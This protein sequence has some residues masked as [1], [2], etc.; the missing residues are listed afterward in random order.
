MYSR[1]S[2]NSRSKRSREPTSGERRAATTS[3]AMR[4]TRERAEGT[5][6]GPGGK[7]EGATES[8][9]RD[10][11]R[12]GAMRKSDAE[13]AGVG[14]S[15]RGKARGREP[16][17]AGTRC[18]LPLRWRGGNDSR[19]TPFERPLAHLDAYTPVGGNSLAPLLARSPACSLA[20][21]RPLLCRSAPPLHP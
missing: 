4:T 1:H 17:M 5:G 7:G 19:G 2:A 18:A 10:E 15:G 3:E 6:S 8:G 20:H 21:A 12:A 9:K 16:A 14:P 13:A 11:G